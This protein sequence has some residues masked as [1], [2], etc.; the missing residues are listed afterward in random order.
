MG[1]RH[2]VP[3]NG[4][5]HDDAGSGNVF[6]SCFDGQHIVDPGR[7]DKVD[8]HAPDNPCQ[9]LAMG[10]VI[11]FGMAD[12]CKPQIVRPAPLEEMQVAC[13]IDHTR[14]IRVLIVDPLDQ[15]VAE[16][17]QLAGQPF[18]KITHCPFPCHS[19][20]RYMRQRNRIGKMRLLAG[21]FILLMGLAPSN[22]ATF[23][24]RRGIS[25]DIWSTWPEE[26][27][28]ADEA[29]LFPFPEWRRSLKSEDIKA[30]K[31]AGYDF[32]RLPID[33]APFLSEAASANRDRLYAETEAAI[34]MVLD[35]GLGVIVDMHAIP[36]GSR[37]IGT[38]EY[39]TKPELF[40]A[41]LEHLRRMAML[42]KTRD[43]RQVALELFNEPT[44]DCDDSGTNDWPDMMKQAF[45]AA[46]ASATKLTLV[47][48]GACWGGAEGLAKIDARDFPDDNLIWSFHSYDPFILTHQGA[49]WAGDF[50]PHVTGLPFPLDG[51][52]PDKLKTL[53]ENV[54]SAITSDAP[55]DRRDGHLAYLDDEIAKIATADG[56]NTAMDKAF[57][58]A[59]DWAKSNGVDPA[60]I[61]LGEFGMINQEY[62]RPTPVDP[63]SRQAY[64]AAQIRRAEDHGF[65]WA[66]F[67]YG[68]AFALM[69]D[70]D[71][72]AIEP[73]I[74]P[75][76]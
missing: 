65:R 25:L 43:P 4:L 63:K 9:L 51:V 32:V 66:A 26:S 3:E 53:V 6:G 13:M 52:A 12:A 41:Y 61:L 71:G 64:Y 75:G 27:R 8:F 40:E 54:R 70:W 19:F 33:P 72:M 68:G 29:A 21:L 73:V 34:S 11:E 7:G 57:D 45:A 14:E 38:Q 20:R 47:L 69:R 5:F 16:I 56:L 59:A 42:I 28:W 1:K 62:N 74:K 46:R 17:G 44:I 2:A 31:E 49:T 37:S 24:G 22:A 58:I 15:P 76:G 48:S 50:M 55:R 35:E 30:L 60:D 10:T 18:T 23:E 36:A 67:A 39:L